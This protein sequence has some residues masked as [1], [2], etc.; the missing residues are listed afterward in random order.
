[1]WKLVSSVSSGSFSL[2]APLLLPPASWSGKPHRN[3]KQ[4]KKKFTKWN[5]VFR[6]HQMKVRAPP[7]PNGVLAP[8]H[9]LSNPVGPMRWMRQCALSQGRSLS[10]SAI[11]H[12]YE[13]DP[14]VC[15]FKLELG[16]SSVV[17]FPF[18]CEHFQHFLNAGLKFWV[19][20]NVFLQIYYTLLGQ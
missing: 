10:W 19:S 11:T 1:M 15:P 13:R 5:W 6:N 17:L 8:F 9:S 18:S 20:K 16:S 4:N 12:R 14:V 2:P 7:K 3:R